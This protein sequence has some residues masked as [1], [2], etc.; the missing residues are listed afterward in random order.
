MDFFSLGLIAGA[1]VTAIVQMG[2]SLQLQVVAEGVET[3]GQE[4]LL[5]SLECGLAQG[6]RFAPPLT[7]AQAA[8]WLQGR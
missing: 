2:R 8:D 4:A 5:R 1:I 7:A 3:A 6:Y